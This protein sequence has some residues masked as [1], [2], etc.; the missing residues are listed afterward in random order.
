MSRVHHDIWVW[1]RELALS[2][3]G[4]SGNSASTEPGAPTKPIWDMVLGEHDLADPVTIL[5]CHGEPVTLKYK[6]A[7]RIRSILAACNLQYSDTGRGF[8]GSQVAKRLDVGQA[9]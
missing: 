6:T 4:V 2:Q 9:K 7:Y 1:S 5:G 3:V 8:S